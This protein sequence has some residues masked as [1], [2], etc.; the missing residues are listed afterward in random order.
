MLKIQGNTVNPDEAS[1]LD[2]QFLQIHLLLCLACQGL[3]V[4]SHWIEDNQ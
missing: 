3:K 1:H 4:K 2:Q